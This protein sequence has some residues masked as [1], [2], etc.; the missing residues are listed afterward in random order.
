VQTGARNDVALMLLLARTQSLSGRAH[1]AL[2]MLQRITQLKGG[3][4]DAETSDDFRRV[5]A[6][7]GWEA[8]LAAAQDN[9]A[10]SS[11]SSAAGAGKPTDKP[12]AGSTAP[13]PPAA[14][15]AR[16][17]PA[18]KT[19]A[20]VAP[21]NAPEAPKAPDAPA[22]PAAP[23]TP[24]AP[25]ALTAA[26]ALAPESPLKVPSAVMAPFA[27]AYDRVSRRVVFADEG[28]D[29]LR[30]LDELAGNVVNLVSPD[31]IAPYRP[32]AIAIDD[33]RGD[34][35]VAAV[36]ETDS[37]KPR[38]KLLKLQLV[39]GRQLQMIELPADSGAVRLIGVAVA[40]SGVYALDALGRRIF[41]LATD[42]KTP[43]VYMPTYGLGTPTGFTL[44]SGTTAFVSFANGVAR[45]NLSNRTSI[46]V[47]AVKA[48]DLADLHSIAA[49]GNTILA[50]QKQP[51]GTFEAVRIEL[52][53]SGRTAVA[54][55]VVEQAAAPAATLVGNTY[56]FLA[57]HG[58]DRVIRKLTLK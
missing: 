35:W 20:A 18:P 13:A 22:A 11:D 26:A 16:E 24:P 41:A 21:A 46:P 43:R 27:L 9:D 39:S 36:D 6:L 33:R 52:N 23:G 14:T 48:D 29:T 55:H 3:I 7:P 8:L 2:V 25:P 40:P 31:W 47:P 28:T 58:D 56:F 54:R 37:A 32:T 10:L 42:S 30:I 15:R 53:R 57:Q 1:D 51:D 4:A 34:L 44:A 5:R 45:L 17:A 19:P 12:L 50:V 38:S 49:Y